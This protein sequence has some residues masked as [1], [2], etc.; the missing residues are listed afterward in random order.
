MMGPSSRCCQCSP[1]KSIGTLWVSYATMDNSFTH[2]NYLST[3]LSEELRCLFQNQGHFWSDKDVMT[4][5]KLSIKRQRCV[6]K[7]SIFCLPSGIVSHDCSEVT[8]QA[9]STVHNSN[10]PIDTL[11]FLHVSLSSGHRLGLQ[12]S[13]PECYLYPNMRFSKCCNVHSSWIHCK[14]W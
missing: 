13:H 12:E 6:D 3:C 7:C 11:T 10:K 5:E 4:L 9:E 14:S 1:Q 8:S 2:I